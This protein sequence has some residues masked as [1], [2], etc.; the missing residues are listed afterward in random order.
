MLKLLKLQKDNYIKDI[1]IWDRK[2]FILI[3]YSLKLLKGNL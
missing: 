2:Y 3:F 1:H